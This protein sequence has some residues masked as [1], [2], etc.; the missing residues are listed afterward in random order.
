MSREIAESFGSRIVRATL[1]GLLLLLP[2]SAARA[3]V[4]SDNPDG[5]DQVDNTPR[6]YFEPIAGLTTIRHL[7]PAET[8]IPLGTILEL[9][10]S[11]PEDAVVTFTGAAITSRTPDGVSARCPLDRVG[12]ALVAAV[13]ELSDGT[14]RVLP[15]R[16][17]VLP[18]AVG[19]IRATMLTPTIAT[20]DLHQG[21][22][23][24]ETMA[25]FFGES[26]ARLEE[27][28]LGAMDAT[29]NDGG[30]RRPILGAVTRSYRTSTDRRIEFLP[31]VDPPEFATL[32]EWRIDGHA[33]SIGAVRVDTF[34]TAGSRTV[35]VGPPT[36]STKVR[37]DTYSVSI[38]S[39]RNQV[40]H[41]LDGQ[42]I[43]FEAVT[44]PPG[45]EGHITWISSTKHGTAVPVLGQGATFTVVFN[46]TFGPHPDGGTSQWLG[47]RADNAVFGQDEKVSDCCEERVDP[48]ATNT[49]V[50]SSI[51]FDATHGSDV[52]AIPAGFF[53][54]GS[55]VFVGTV[56]LVGMPRNG[57]SGVQCDTAD[58]F[59]VRDGPVICP[60]PPPSACN[61]VGIKMRGLRLSA[62]E[63]ITVTYNFGQNPETWLLALAATTQQTGGVLRAN[64]DTAN[65]GTYEAILPVNVMVVLVRE[66]AA[67]AP[68]PDDIKKLYR[69]VDMDVAPGVPWTRITPT[70][71]GFFCTPEGA[72][73][74]NEFFPGDP[75][76]E[77]AA[78]AR[79]DT[80]AA[81]GVA[82]DICLTCTGAGCHG[83]NRPHSHC[84]CR[85][86]P[87]PKR[88]RYTKAL[89]IPFPF[90]T[91]PSVAPSPLISPFSCN[92]ALFPDPDECCDSSRI[93]A[94]GMGLF[95]CI[96]GGFEIAIYTNDR[97]CFP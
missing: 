68:G 28:T 6:L 11:V 78:D 60:D 52:I 2:I 54:T 21:A 31:E 82:C 65:G 43:T 90:C 79:D 25:Y 38:T 93:P 17:I 5:E 42:S 92:E 41:V 84:I 73:I 33:I 86:I 62:T 10:L 9:Y 7:A 67:L 89:G 74:G 57:L 44:D 53:G 40:D 47:V 88:C 22:T 48:F 18:V 72:D 35:S 30:R 49:T 83:V 55:D 70:D 29:S 96:F 3:D 37:I 94:F 39:H 20:F 51:T 27:T 12:T 16:L 56:E 66:S 15:V 91:G 4:A 1:V 8:A 81:E 69:T 59:I 14:R 61:P 23:N 76:S 64:L 77:P 19:D 85:P 32:M 13:V 97:L 24:A 46:E 63:P 50:P 80:V 58:T 75:G 87:C 26:V 95:P 71:G 34:G 45:N 36:R